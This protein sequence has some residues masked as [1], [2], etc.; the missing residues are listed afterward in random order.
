MTLTQKRAKLYQ[1]ETE[2]SFWE[3]VEQNY[4]R[5]KG[6][7]RIEPMSVPLDLNDPMRTAIHAILEAHIRSQRER[8]QKTFE[9]ACRLDCDGKEA[10]A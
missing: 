3:R 7:S 8:L 5:T 2:M 10:T 1:I 6:Y 4:E 9:A